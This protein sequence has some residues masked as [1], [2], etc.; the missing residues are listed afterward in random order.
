[1]KRHKAGATLGTWSQ[2]HHSSECSIGARGQDPVG[3]VYLDGTDWLSIPD[4]ADMQPSD[5]NGDKPFT[6]EQWVKVEEFVDGRSTFDVNGDYMLLYQNYGEDRNNNA[7]ITILGDSDEQHPHRATCGVRDENHDS[8]S[9][10]SSTSLV[11]DEWIHIACVFKRDDIDV[12]PG[13]EDGY[14]DEELILYMNGKLEDFSHTAMQ[15]IR[16]GGGAPILLGAHGWISDMGPNDG[17][18]RESFSNRFKG[19]I[20]QFKYWDVPLSAYEIQKGMFSMPDTFDPHLVAYAAFHGDSPLRT[21]EDTGAQHD[22][23]LMTHGADGSVQPKLQATTVLV[24]TVTIRGDCSTGSTN[25]QSALACPQRLTSYPAGRIEVFHPTVGWGTVC[26]HGYWQDDGAANVVCRALGYTSGSLYTYGVSHVTNSLMPI[27]AGWRTCQGTESSILDCSPDGAPTDRECRYGCDSSCTHSLDQGA[28]CF[29]SATH[30]GSLQP[31]IRTCTGMDRYATLGPASA[32]VDQ[33]VRFGCIEYQT[34]RCEFST[35]AADNGGTAATVVQATRAFAICAE[36]GEEQGFCHG[37]LSTSSH[38][39]NQDVC[40]PPP[41]CSGRVTAW[42]QDGSCFTATGVGTD[43]NNGGAGTC[44]GL[45]G[46]G[47]PANGCTCAIRD[48]RTQAI[49]TI[50]Y[51]PGASLTDC[52]RVQIGFHIRIPFAVNVAG[53]FSFRLHADYG[54]G[55]YFGI[56]GM[57]HTGGGMWGHGQT[58]ATSLNAGDHE[59][60]S[61]GFEDCCDGHAELEVHLLCDGPNSPWRIVQTSKNS[62]TAAAG[63]ACYQC[64]TSAASVA[65]LN[66]ASETDT[67]CGAT[68]AMMQTGVCADAVECGTPGADWHC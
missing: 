63:Q 27:V 47:V 36:T 24:R 42:L 45:F 39:S 32:D 46:H 23:Q 4:H 20:A 6:V 26:G 52:L 48:V 28:T 44:D 54:R 3:A 64:S 37:L 21:A 34:A 60:E 65:Q 1:M 14:E 25:I 12:A 31:Q 59:F 40:A 30:L 55:G 15:G 2:W 11:L 49:L 9:L 56:N 43:C 51:V 68:G 57:S 66:C 19:R 41:G 58:D 62:D 5:K 16:N 33:E 67:Q 17:S 7:W 38:L 10:H 13:A 35:L 8:I 29:N 22:M 53:S 61:L 50:T 18:R